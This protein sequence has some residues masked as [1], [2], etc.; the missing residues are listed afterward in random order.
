MASAA[1]YALIVSFS[2]LDSLMLCTTSLAS[3]IICW[4]AALLMVLDY[5]GA[6][7]LLMRVPDEGG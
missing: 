5:F 7:V 2:A 6:F 1:F 4:S 3:C